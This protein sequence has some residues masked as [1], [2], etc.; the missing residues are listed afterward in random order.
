M[1]RVVLIA[2][3]SLGIVHAGVLDF[4]FGKDN[5]DG[6]V[7]TFAEGESM[8]RHEPKGHRGGRMLFGCYV[9][10]RTF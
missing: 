10:K 2:V 1:R 4:I 6:D 3:L 7:E 9:R 8:L 5:T